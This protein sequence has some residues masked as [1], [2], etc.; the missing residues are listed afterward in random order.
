MGRMRTRE[1][2]TQ[3]CENAKRNTACSIELTRGALASPGRLQL[4]C[5][6][7]RKA[8]TGLAR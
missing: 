2:G 6:R 1:M 7:N 3:S 8:W 4:Q 5:G